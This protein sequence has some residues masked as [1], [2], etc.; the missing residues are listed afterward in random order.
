MDRAARHTT[1]TAALS[2]PIALPC[3]P[4]SSAFPPSSPCPRHGEQSV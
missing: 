1:R 3:I 2:A 4:A